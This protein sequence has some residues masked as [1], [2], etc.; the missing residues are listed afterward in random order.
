MNK[1][2][3]EELLKIDDIDGGLIGT[4]SLSLDEFL[5]ILNTAVK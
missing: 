3:V 1:K 5:P 4:A 2:N